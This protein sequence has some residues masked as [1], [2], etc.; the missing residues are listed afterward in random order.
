MNYVNNIPTTNN[1]LNDFILINLYY[2]N[3]TF[4]GLGNII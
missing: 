1:K 4:S 3:L 2:F